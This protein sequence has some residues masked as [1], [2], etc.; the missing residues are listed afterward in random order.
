MP[1][2]AQGSVLEKTTA[3]FLLSFRKSGISIS[4]FLVTFG[5]FST[6][7]PHSTGHRMTNKSLLPTVKSCG[8]CDWGSLR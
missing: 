1:L 2:K 3:G 5:V 8:T 7:S 4:G 6:A